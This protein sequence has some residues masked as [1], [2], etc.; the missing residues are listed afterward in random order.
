MIK[1][2]YADHREL[3]DAPAVTP[4]VY[5]VD[6]DWYHAEGWN[7]SSELTPVHPRSSKN[8]RLAVETAAY[9]FKREFGFDFAQYTADEDTGPKDR[10]FAMVHI[11]AD[12]KDGVFGVISFRWREWKDDPPAYALQWV[13]FHP[14]ERRQGHLSKFWPQ[15][16]E[17]LG[18]FIVEGPLSEAM[19]AFLKKHGECPNCGREPRLTRCKLDRCHSY[20]P[21]QN[22]VLE[23]LRALV[24]HDRAADKRAHLDGCFELEQAED[25]LQEIDSK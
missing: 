14:W 11:R 5:N 22:A 25:I 21:P 2:L 17:K 9:F 13:W 6:P 19:Y 23:A 3:I 15:F 10:I 7:F 1:R 16:R 18:N 8:L 12:G 20:T 4:W 24:F